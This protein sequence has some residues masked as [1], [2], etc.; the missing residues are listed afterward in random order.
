M[1]D[2][3]KQK[4]GD[5]LD[6]AWFVNYNIM[7]QYPDIDQSYARVV[8]SGLPLKFYN[9]DERIFLRRSNSRIYPR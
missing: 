5:W 8:E 6:D 4:W 3:L 9:H 7:H 1:A 2:E